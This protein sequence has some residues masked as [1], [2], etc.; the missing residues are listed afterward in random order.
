MSDPAGAWP[1]RH[2]IRV[3]YQEIDMQRVVF[4][5][6]YLA[7]CDEVMAGWMAEAFGWSGFDDRIDW[8]LVKLVLEWQGSATFGDVMAVDCGIARWGTTSFDVSFRG[9]VGERPVFTATITYVCVAPGTTTKMAVPDEVR[10]A[11]SPVPAEP[12]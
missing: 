7:Y 6:H 10:H 2:S 5:A 4:N 3:R 8:M 12:G 9:L 11:L 1:Y